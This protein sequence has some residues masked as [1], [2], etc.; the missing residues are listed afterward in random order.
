M[1]Q[2]SRVCTKGDDMEDDWTLEKRQTQMTCFDENY[3]WNEI[4][5]PASLSLW[6]FK[7]QGQPKF[8]LTAGKLQA[9]CHLTGSLSKHVE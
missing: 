2:S 8:C 9:V 5:L 7:Q 6:Q 1:I 4:F 3:L